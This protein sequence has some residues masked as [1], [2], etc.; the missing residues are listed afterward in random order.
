MDPKQR[1]LI[2]FVHASL[3]L[4]LS[5]VTLTVQAQRPLGTDVSGYQPEYLNWTAIKSDGVSF[6]WVKATQGTGYENPY[7]TA[8]LTGAASAGVYA[9]AYHYATPSQDPNITGANSAD[10]EAAYFWSIAGSYVKAGG[11][12]L[13]PMLDW[14]DTGATNGRSGMTTTFMSEWLNEWCNDVSNYATA[15]GLKIRPV[16]YSG[17]WY[18]VPTSGG[19]GYPGLNSTVTNWPDW[20]AAYPAVANAQTGNPGGESPWPGWNIWQYGDTNWSGGDSDVYNGNFQNFLATFAI[21]GTNAPYFVSAPTNV[22][23]G[24]GSNATLYARAT[25][26]A[27][28]FQWYFNGHAI[29]GA[30]SSNYT[31]VDV[32]L[33]NA[34]AYTVTASNSYASIP[35]AATLS[36]LGRLVNNPGSILDPSN[37]V[38]WWTGDGNPNDVYGVTNATPFGGITYTNSKVGLGF[39]LNGSSSYLSNNAA[40][41]APPWTASVWVYRQNAAG[42]S[43][44]L[45]GDQTYALKLEQ[46]NTTR[47]VGISHSGVADYLFSPAYSVPLNKWTHLAFVATS[48][49]V[50]LYTNGVQEGST[51]VSGFELPRSY[52]GVDWFSTLAGIYTDY[53]LGDINDLQIY[54]RAL[55][56]SEIKSIYNAGSAGLVRAPELIGITGLGNGQFGV[57][58]IGQTGK[59][60]TVK[61]S[62]D[63]INWSSAGTVLNPTGATSYTGP[64]STSQ[65][66]YQATQNY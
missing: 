40:E 5:L 38:N 18:T 50:M 4:S 14:E 37:M 16:V 35:A 36:V 56:A 26:N 22:T 7:F 48:S 64:S 29:P 53:L 28:N 20:F 3:I 46:Y 39:S 8:Q 51:N 44:T 12:Y 62:P 58:L 31:M 25:G 49:T 1:P 21:G 45:L 59:P 65:R 54:T 57:Y 52:V 15:D 42:A 33:T 17:T 41:I 24:S 61:T 34:G 60:I 43:A 9:G 10:S 6:A 13:V 30:T 47:D 63:L 66:F 55:A 2:S 27:L 19:F 11:G 23:V 32:E